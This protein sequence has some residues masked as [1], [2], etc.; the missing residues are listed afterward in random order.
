MTLC[1]CGCGRPAPIYNQ[2]HPKR[3]IVRGQAA[4]FIQGHQ[5]RE[6]LRRRRVHNS[7][8]GNEHAAIAERVL[9]KRLPDG[10]E[11]HHIDGDRRNNANRNLV[12]CQ[13]NAY[14]TLLHMRS[15]TVRAGGDPNSHRLC[16]ACDCVKPLDAFSRHRGKKLRGRTSRCL[17]C[18]RKAFK[19]WWNAGGSAK[20]SA[21][22]K[23]RQLP[24]RPALGGHAVRHRHA[25][26]GHGG[27]GVTK[28]AS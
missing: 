1:E 22:R 13:D 11:V 16:R 23:G 21:R 6:H 2:S 3:G 19:A 28:G 12:I 27:S 17:E 7:Y 8:R 25:G 5:L 10:S 18:G 26:R 20:H 24:R 4:R 14:H 9:G 15:E